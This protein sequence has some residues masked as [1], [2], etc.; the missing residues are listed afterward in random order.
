MTIETNILREWDGIV[1]SAAI[2][3]ITI[4]AIGVIVRAV[5]LSDVAKHLGTILCILILMLMLPAI[6][7]SAWSS[8]S[9]WQQLGVFALGIMIGL[10]L[11]ALRQPRKKRKE[12]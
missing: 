4:L 8:M 11:W 12:R 6:I 2:I 1:E 9:Y 5:K 7:A 10:L 3:A